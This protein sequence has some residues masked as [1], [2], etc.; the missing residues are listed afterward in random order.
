MIAASIRQAALTWPSLR[1][2]EA[3]NSME[4]GIVCAFLENHEC[5]PYLHEST[6]VHMATMWLVVA[7]ALEEGK[8]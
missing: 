8:P 2:R 1:T 7:G 3:T 5:Y 6:P 4:F